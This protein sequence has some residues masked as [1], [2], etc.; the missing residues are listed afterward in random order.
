MR[1]ATTI[2]V[3]RER[4]RVGRRVS[5]AWGAFALLSL[6]VGAS[7]QHY[8]FH[9]PFPDELSPIPVRDV[10]Q[11]HQGFIWFIQ[12]RTLYRYDGTQVLPVYTL[13]GDELT[14]LASDPQGNI[15]LGTR[16]GGL[17]IW[18]R[19]S[20]EISPWLDPLDD[21]GL[22]GFVTA[23]AADARGFL[24]AATSTGNLVR[25]DLT[26]RRAT[27]FAPPDIRPRQPEGL[28]IATLT[29]SGAPYVWLGTAAGEVYRHGLEDDVFEPLET[30]HSGAEISAL[31]EGQGDRLWI[32]TR[33]VEL[34]LVDEHSLEA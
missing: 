11:D 24:W 27:H 17:Q 1:G 2:W 4:D 13:K 18:Q 12:Q 15:W 25:I 21:S 20:R 32:G 23:L 29:V 6:A 14:A 5:V 16:D 34:I 30:G 8:R 28:D 33:A 31:A 10:Q 22:V 9:R 26:T 19:G 7:E 3:P